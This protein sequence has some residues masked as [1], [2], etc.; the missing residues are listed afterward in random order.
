MTAD[1]EAR[2]RGRRAAAVAAPI[3]VAGVAAGLVLS[4]PPWR[5]QHTAAAAAVTLGT[6]P[7]VRTDLVNTVQVSGS[8]G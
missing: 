8:L 5:S 6:A 4:G 1:R 7:L 2:R 3:A